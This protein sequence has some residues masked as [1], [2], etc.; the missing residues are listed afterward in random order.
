MLAV[1]RAHPRGRHVTVIGVVT[2]DPAG[3]VEFLTPAGPHPGTRSAGPLPERL[4]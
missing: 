1:L 2:A 4:P 3:D